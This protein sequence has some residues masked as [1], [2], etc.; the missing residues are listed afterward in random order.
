MNFNNWKNEYRVHLYF[1]GTTLAT[2]L[3]NIINEMK[4]KRSK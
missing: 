1:C 2:M 3:H 4:V